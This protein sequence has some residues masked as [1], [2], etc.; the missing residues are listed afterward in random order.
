MSSDAIIKTR[1]YKGICLQEKMR[2]KN[3][4]ENL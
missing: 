1:H 3:D 4:M 2:G